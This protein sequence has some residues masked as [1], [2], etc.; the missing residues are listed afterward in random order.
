MKNNSLHA[1]VDG[2]KASVAI[3]ELDAVT[4]EQY[5]Q[6]CAFVLARAHARTEDP[7]PIYGYLGKSE[8]FD[9]A[10]TKFA[11]AYADQNEKDHEAL[12]DAIKKGKVQTA[13]N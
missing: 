9:E 4:L 1:A 7:A 8:V 2:R 13:T 5:A 11:L 6:V 10:L 3:D 12:L